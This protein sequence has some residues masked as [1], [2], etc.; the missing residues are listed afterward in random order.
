MQQLDGQFFPAGQEDVRIQYVHHN[1]PHVVLSG[2]SDQ[3]VRD[4]ARL[5]SSP[6]ALR[7]HQRTL[8]RGYLALLPVGSVGL[9]QVPLSV[10]MEGA[11]LVLRKPQEDESEATADPPNL[12]AT[13]FAGHEVTARATAHPAVPAAIAHAPAGPSRAAGAWRRPFRWDDAA[14]PGCGPQHGQARCPAGRCCSASGRC[15]PTGPYCDADHLKAYDG[16]FAGVALAEQG[17]PMCGAGAQRIRAEAPCKAAATQLGH[18]YGGSG[19]WP[20]EP[21]GCHLYVEGRPTV[22]F[23]DLAGIVEYGH[24]APVCIRADHWSGSTA[25]NDCPE[26]FQKMGTEDQCR[27]A[28][29]ASGRPFGGT[30]AW[31][32]EPSGCHIYGGPEAGSQAVFLNIALPGT[33]NPHSAPLCQRSEKADVAW[34]VFGSLEC[35][36]GFETAATEA[37]CEPAVGAMGLPYSGPV[38][39]PS[40]PAGCVY[41]HLYGHGYWNTAAPRRAWAAAAP[42]CR[43]AGHAIPPPPTGTAIPPSPPAPPPTSLPALNGSALS[44]LSTGELEPSTGERDAMEHP[45]IHVEAEGNVHVGLGGL[46]GVQAHGQAALKVSSVGASAVRSGESEPWGSRA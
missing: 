23:N 30:S 45:G 15:G 18:P 1:F 5:L 44:G 17:A 13:P 35:W 3:V 16:P 38:S 25:T 43:R 34:G 10:P 20:A 7:R 14:A 27:T 19:S 31:P 33:A 41:T 28:A 6:A 11:D 46:G 36:P 37:D 4:L 29:A 12:P 24:S 21:A 39:I 32:A 9:A 2:Y 26:F 40:V 8:T 22:H 42:V